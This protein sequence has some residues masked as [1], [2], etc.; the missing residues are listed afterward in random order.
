LRDV[1]PDREIVLQMR[2]EELAPILLRIVPGHIQ[3]GMFTT[4]TVGQVQSGRSDER[5]PLT[6]VAETDLRSIAA[7]K[8]AIGNWH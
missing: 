6:A 4:E 3:N 8:L 1:L 7:N 2:P 5:L